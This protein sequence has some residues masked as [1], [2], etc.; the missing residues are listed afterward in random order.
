MFLRK[1][2]TQKPALPHTPTHVCGKHLTCDKFGIA[3]CAAVDVDD[4]PFRDGR[5]PQVPPRITLAGTGMRC[6][7]R[8]K[9][10][11][12]KRM[13]MPLN[14]GANCFLEGVDIR[15]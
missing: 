7:V 8:C 11:G 5:A 15:A 14:E 1:K 2:G 13:D 3:A 10:N 4:G 9:D 12:V 6:R